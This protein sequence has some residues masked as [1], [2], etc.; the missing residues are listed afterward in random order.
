MKSDKDENIRWVLDRQKEDNSEIKK[1]ARRYI[2]GVL[3]ALV[4]L[5]GAWYQSDGLLLS[6]EEMAIILA[7]E[8]VFWQSG[9]FSSEHA[10]AFITPLNN[11]PAIFAGISGALLL[12]SLSAAYKIERAPD[13]QPTGNAQKLI[14]EDYDRVW[15]W[16]CYNDKLVDKKEEARIKSMEMGGISIT[17]LILSFGLYFFLSH[18]LF[19]YFILLFYA[20]FYTFYKF[21]TI[22]YLKDSHMRKGV[23]VT[24][25]FML[26]TRPIH[27]FQE[28]TNYALSGKW[29]VFLSL[30]CLIISLSYLWPDVRR[31]KT[32]ITEILSKIK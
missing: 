9:L 10:S 24:L 12:F 29:F 19:V 6:S 31:H 13:C 28:L 25:I 11:L 20:V 5:I 3:S 1:Q 30:I 7:K 18:L 32:D 14:S 21:H 23:G 16:I 27:L 26:I 4:V 8:G 17:L 22:E 2:F 15:N